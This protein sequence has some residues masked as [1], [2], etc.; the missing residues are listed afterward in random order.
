MS[1]NK[2]NGAK[3]KQQQE[4]AKGSGG[5]LDQDGAMAQIIISKATS[6][7]DRNG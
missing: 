6:G 3:A 4:Q 2:R 5:A 7:Q 1:L